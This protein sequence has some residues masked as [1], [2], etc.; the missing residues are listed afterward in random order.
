MKVNILVLSLISIVIV[1]LSGCDSTAKQAEFKMPPQQV[2]IVLMKE[3]LVSFESRLPARAVASAVAEVRP[4]V[5]GIV[6]KRLFTEGSQVSAGQALY[7]IDDTIYQAN[8]ASAMAELARAQANLQ[9]AKAEMSRYQQLLKD[10]A[11]SQQTFDQAEANYLAV[12]AEIAVRKAAIGKAQVDINYTKVLAPISGK[13]SKSNITVGALVTAAQSQ[14][15]ATIT[16]LDPIYFDL[17]QANGELR[18][19][20]NRLASGE[21]TAVKQTAQ[22]YFSKN[23]MYPLKGELKFNEVQTNPSTD[24]VTLRVEFSNP[25]QALL[26]GMYAQVTLT[27][28]VREHSILVPQQAVSFNNKGHANVFLLGDEN[29]VESKEITIGRSF[30]HQWLVIA[31]LS[32]GDK[33][34]TSGL[35]KIGPGM[36]VEPLAQKNKAA[37]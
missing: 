35:Q 36:V 18:K 5:T 28:A 23:E 7:Q 15:L 11:T 30:N 1:T 19:I 24:T 3:Q 37:Q 2:D 9:S 27:Q 20:R 10:K 14:V 32:A 17:V 21:L 4:Q 26:P 31:G 6:L 29:K 25:N 12:K 8:L 13:I 16:Q 34:I 33:V 22:L